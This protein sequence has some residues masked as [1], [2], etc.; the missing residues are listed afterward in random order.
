MRQSETLAID[1]IKLFI[2]MRAC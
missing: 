1:A 2:N